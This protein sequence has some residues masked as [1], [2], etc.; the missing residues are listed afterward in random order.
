[1]GFRSKRTL[2]ELRAAGETEIA[3]EHIQ[4]W[5]ELDEIDPGFQL[6]T[7]EKIATVIFFISI[8]IT[9]II[10]FTILLFFQF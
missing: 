2:I 9:Y 10:K 7:K 6:L 5:F 4:Y 3:Q 1:M 8:G